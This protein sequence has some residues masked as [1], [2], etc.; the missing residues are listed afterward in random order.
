MNVLSL[1]PACGQKYIN[2]LMLRTIAL[3][4]SLAMLYGVC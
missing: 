1:Q 2:L 3:D 4:I